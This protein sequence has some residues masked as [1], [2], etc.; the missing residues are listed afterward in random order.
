MRLCANRHIILILLIFIF[1][2]SEDGVKVYRVA[3]SL[4]NLKIKEDVEDRSS[5]SMSWEAPSS[6]TPSSGSKMRLASYSIPYSD[7]IGD[8]SIM[9]LSGDG[10]GLEANINRWRNQIGLISETLY[11]INES[12]DK[13]INEIGMYYMFEIVNPE[14][15]ESAFLCSIIPNNGSTIFVKLTVTLRGVSEIRNDFKYFCDS[16]KISNE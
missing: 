13:R 14:N 15:S 8:L 16:F 1:A 5:R 2:C 7:G 4:S 10:G 6:W 9:T 3:K 12:A 11:S